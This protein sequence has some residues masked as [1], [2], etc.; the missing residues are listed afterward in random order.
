M[1]GKVF[2]ITRVHVGSIENNGIYARVG[3]H[4][5]VFANHPFVVGAIVTKQRL[6][7][8]M[9][10]VAGIVEPVFLPGFGVLRLGREFRVS[11]ENFVVIAHE[12]VVVP[13]VVEHPNGAIGL[14][15]ARQLR[16][17]DVAAQTVNGDPG[18]GENVARRRAL[19]ASGQRN[20]KSERR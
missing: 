18:V 14:G 7:P 1:F 9:A 11:L 16:P 8:M 10:R 13:D 15:R 20:R 17:G 2:I 12:W 3:Q 19:S 5:R 4:L 6:A